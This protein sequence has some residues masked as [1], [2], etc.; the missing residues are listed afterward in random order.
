MKW[1]HISDIHF[2]IGG[3]DSQKI[4]QQLINKLEE[5][6]ENVDFILITGDCLYQNRGTNK[7]NKS[8]STYIK[9]IA[10]KCSCSTIYI[11]QGNHDVNREDNARNNLIEKI[12]QKKGDFSANYD[13]LSENGNEKFQNIYTDV[14]GKDYEAYEVFAPEL[15]PYRVISIN[16][17]LI[18]KD[19]NDY[20]KL[21]VCNQKLDEL[22]SMI[23]DDERIN[24]LIM[25]HG[26]ECLELEDARKL[27]HW[28]EDN[29]IDIVYCGHTHRAAVETYND[30]FRDVK[31]FTAGAIVLDDYAIPGFYI[32]E[33][34]EQQGQITLTLYTYGKSTE[35][36][37]LDNHNLRKFKNGKY[38][39]NL[40]RHTK[41]LD[42]KRNSSAKKCKTTIDE[43][44]HRYTKKFGENKIYSNKYEGNEVFNSWKIIHSLAE[45]GVPYVQA[46]EITS[47]VIDIITDEKFKS[48]DNIL[49][50]Q[51]LRTIVFDAISHFKIKETKSELEISCWASRY[52][53]KYSGNTVIMVLDNYGGKE[54]LNYYYIKNKL[55]K[56]VMDS[57]TGNTV[58][59]D[60]LI[61]NE[62]TKM[63]ESVLGFLKNMGIFEIRKEALIELIRE[64]ITQK[65][66]PW[67]VCNNREKLIEYN[68]RQAE[69][70]VNSLRRGDNQS[71][72]SQIEAAYH[73]CAV[74]LG[75]YDDYIGC[76]ETSPITILYRAITHYRNKEQTI[77]AALPMQ[78][79]QIV[80]LKKDLECQG[81]AFTEFVE[82]INVINE[83]I[84]KS[85][86]ITLD[87]TENA[88]FILWG[89]IK[90]LEGKYNDSHC[91]EKN[92]LDRIMNIF[93]KGKGFVVKS[94][95]RD[96]KDCFWFEPNWEEHEA[97]PQHL[98]KQMLVCMIEKIEDLEGIF[99]YLYMQNKRE[100]L[101]EI[102]FVLK[103]LSA[104][105]NMFRKHVRDRFKGKYLKCIFIQ[106]DNFKQISLAR[107]WRNIFYEIICKSKIS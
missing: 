105:T 58:F 20:Q 17:S 78:K 49:S 54:R 92:N 83:N 65:P 84:V 85:H 88:L 76:T 79:F 103:D 70:H 57:I 75:Q 44:N 100:T 29:N 32:C 43:F 40:S 31:Q 1:L 8:I 28:I 67:I 11:C 47:N 71:V 15:E 51:E 36:W 56:E 37:A 3:Y 93:S 63:S 66:H 14:T 10:E 74:I 18:S 97:T 62:L 53:R 19:K 106:D 48:V 24:I 77:S 30:I 61:G 81:V 102:V 34:D 7:T 13:N 91:C 6:K 101:T 64:Y 12:R 50:C 98:G 52:A 42:G 25:H 23:L 16:T 96:L 27:E 21:K 38:T 60:K 86:K 82:K 9:K 99:A 80:Q 72:I 59:Y 107:D 94:P 26:I 2:N 46:L 45:V 95:L 41:I 39:Y 68:K 5:L 35:E 22:G 33:S 89:M 4:K 69:K 73:I 55:L 104:F 87:E 90:K